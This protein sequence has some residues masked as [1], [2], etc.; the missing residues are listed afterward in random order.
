MT[1]MESL[2]ELEKFLL[3]LELPINKVPNLTDFKKAYRS[4]LHLHLDKGGETE[5]FQEVSE[6]AIK[7]MEFITNNPE[8]QSNVDT[9]EFKDILRC[10]EKSNDV[11]YNKG[12]LVFHID[13]KKRNVWIKAL[14]KKLGSLKTLTNGVQ[15]KQ[16]SW[17]LK[18]DQP[19][20]FG[21]VSATIYTVDEKTG[22]SKVQLQGKSY[23]AY[24]T[25]VIPKI[26]REIRHGEDKIVTSKKEESALEF[27]DVEHF[28]KKKP[29]DIV[30]IDVA[31]TE[32]TGMLVEG[33]HRLE[34]HMVS[35][36]DNLTERV[37]EAATSFKE[38]ST[39]NDIKEQM[40]KLARALEENKT[41]IEKVDK[42]LD[43]IL[44]M[45][46]DESMKTESVD[47]EMISTKIAE[48]AKK[49]LKIEDLTTAI[50]GLKN[51]VGQIEKAKDTSA[52]DKLVHTKLDEVKAA[53]ATISKDVTN[54]GR[55]IDDTFKDVADKGSKSL[56]VLTKMNT[57]IEAL[58]KLG[59]NPVNVSQ[60]SSATNEPKEKTEVTGTKPKTKPAEVTEPSGV[61]LRNAIM[62]SDSIA[63]KC[64]KE[65]L[66]KE[67]QS[68]I[69]VVPTY[70]IEK[71]SE[72]R[73]P[74]NYLNKMLDDELEA[75]KVDFAII[76]VGANDISDL[77][78]DNLDLN[79]L[80]T[81]A[82]DH[83]KNVV[84]LAT[85]AAKKHNI[86]IFIVERAPRNDSE[87]KILL[88]GSANGLYMSL[89]TPVD[90][91]HLVTLP[92]L[93][94]HY[95]MRKDCFLVDGIHPT[96]KGVGLL[97]KDICA[98][99]KAKYTDLRKNNDR[100]HGG[101]HGGQRGNRGFGDWHGQAGHDRQ[102]QGN[103]RGQNNGGNNGFGGYPRPQAGWHQNNQQHRN[104]SN[105]NRGRGWGQPTHGRDPMPDMVKEYIM[106]S[107]MDGPHGRGRY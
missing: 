104:N 34:T 17:I 74:E 29:A 94:N 99:I 15:F 93:S 101:T 98:G 26:L 8:M 102:W 72:S 65:R 51:D 63:L 87:N 82:S 90:K 57:N 54:L 43:R 22:M 62:F 76:A 14:D 86:D 13:E 67:L 46:V 103:Y 71:H 5:K 44:S 6:A 30:D 55:S 1:I 9:E 42:K 48:A 2:K 85:R 24:M 11:S 53:S 39:L 40:D 78:H 49:E 105:Q 69:K 81:A 47:V 12:G 23:L 33:I 20:T 45:K 79:E 38:N 4:K 3:V 25:F 66:E 70:H 84:F 64:G 18:G 68:K 91:L 60:P 95:G 21:S 7:V 35:L 27:D 61:I 16:D 96:N 31:S 36:R 56:E 73:N 28:G 37:D 88:N 80:N 41:E 106:R 19:Q 77:D 58:V 50:E 10:F 75:T 89:I 32:E 52:R 92:S 83:S 97:G 59:V 107:F 100:E